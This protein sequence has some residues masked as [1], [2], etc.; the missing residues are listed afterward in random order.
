MLKPL[1]LFSFGVV[2][3][4]TGCQDSLGIVCTLEARPSVSV[5]VRD[6][7]TGASI[8]S[9]ATLVQQD[10]DFIDSAFFPAGEPQLDPYALSTPRSAERPG[11]YNLTVRRAGYADWERQGVRVTRDRCHVNTVTLTA[12]LIEERP[13]VLVFSRTMGFRHASIPAGQAAIRALG[14]SEGFEVETTEDAAVFTT[15][16]LP[17]YDVVVFLNTTGDVLNAPQQAAFESF[18]SAGGGFVGVHAASDTEYDWPFYGALV[19]A[20]FKSHPAIQNATLQRTAVVH[21]STTALPASFS[22]RDEWYDFQSLPAPSISVLLTIDEA[23]YSGGTMGSP[24]PIS[25]YHEFSGGRAWYT[26]MGHTEEAYSEPLFRA[27]LAAG[28]VW[29]TRR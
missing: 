27:H 22:R 23:S 18:I 9:G 2:V 14:L 16:N 28:I 24:H 15:E 7:A 4:L 8:A 25:W 6:S 21:P 29:A 13:R 19:G 1:R 26:A 3:A 11:V 5:L 17:R 12:R 10:G 20:Y